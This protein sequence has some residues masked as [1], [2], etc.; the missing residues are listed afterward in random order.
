MSYAIHITRTAEK[1]L[2]NAVDYISYVLKNPQAA[3]NLLVETGN[4]IEELASFPEKF[5]LIDDP[6]LK[7]WGIRFTMIKNYIA[8]Y[9]IS[10]ETKSVDIIRFL[11]GKR[12]WHT[13]LKL[14]FTL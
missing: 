6:V 5:A 2:N 4:R 13:I 11:Y 8:F 12:D 14:G 3:D 10:E 7:A 9:R 1:D